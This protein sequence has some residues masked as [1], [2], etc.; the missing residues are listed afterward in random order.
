MTWQSEKFFEALYNSH[1]STTFLLLLCFALCTSVM[2]LHSMKHSLRLNTTYKASYEVLIFSTISLFHLQ[3]QNYI[4]VATGSLGQ[5]LSIAAG[6][7]YCGK[8]YDK[9]R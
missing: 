8:Y 7:A 2:V 5:G 1:S 6:M 3:R 9:A 4:D